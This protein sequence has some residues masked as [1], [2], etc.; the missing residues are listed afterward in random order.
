MYLVGGRRM[1]NRR[2]PLAVSVDNCCTAAKST[3]WGDPQHD[4][5]KSGKPEEV[6]AGHGTLTCQNSHVQVFPKQVA[7]GYRKIPQRVTVLY[8]PERCKELTPEA[9][10]IGMT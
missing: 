7:P 6:L 5:P 3:P 10:L 4:V 9:S 1:R 2:Y 8:R